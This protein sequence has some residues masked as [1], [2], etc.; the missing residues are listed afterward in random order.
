MVA[1]L[2]RLVIELVCF[3]TV[4]SGAPQNVTF[5]ASGATVRKPYYFVQ[6]SVTL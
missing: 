2:M 4:P 1:L 5:E 6:I 3:Y